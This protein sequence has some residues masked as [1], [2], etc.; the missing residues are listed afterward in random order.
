TPGEHRMEPV[1]EVA[2]VHFVNDSKATNPH[3]T[4][5]ALDGLE[6]VVL[7]AGGQSK[8]LDLSPIA[9][10]EAVIGVVAIGEAAPR[11][12]EAF[13]TAGL[14]VVRAASMDEAVERAVAM[15]KPGDTV[16]LSPACASFD[17]FADYRARG[18]AFRAA[19]KRI[20]KGGSS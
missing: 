14:P 5:S 1:G 3:A 13:S 12:D 9:R 16:L 11:L 15:A 8:A 17:M 18:E 2:G 10:A 19:V 20:R 7:I 6:R 4:L